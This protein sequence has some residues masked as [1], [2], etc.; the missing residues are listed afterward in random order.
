MSR[1][2]IVITID[3]RSLEAIDRLANEQVFSN[4]SQAIQTANAE[5]LDRLNRNRLAAQCAEPGIKGGEVYG[6]S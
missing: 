1:A 4:R 3:Q 6:V 5:K 2:R